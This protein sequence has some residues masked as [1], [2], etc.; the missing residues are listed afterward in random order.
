MQGPA[1]FPWFTRL[2]WATYGRREDFSDL[3]EKFA[4]QR[5][6]YSSFKWQ[7]LFVFRLAE[8]L[9]TAAQN[10][11]VQS[12]L[13][14]TYPEWRL[15][16]P[17]G[18]GTETDSRIMSSGHAISGDYF[19]Q[20]KE[21][22]VFHPSLL[23]EVARAL[24]ESPADLVYWN[25]AWTNAEFSK[26]EGLLHRKKFS[27]E[28]LE[29]FDGIGAASI[30]REGLSKTRRFIPQ[31]LEFR[32]ATEEPRFQKQAWVSKPIIGSHL[33]SV[34]LC[35][36]NRALETQS[37]IESLSRQVGKV[38]VELILVDHSSA[39][40][41]RNAVETLSKRLFSSVKIVDYAG[42][43]HFAR[44]NNLAVRSAAAGDLLFFLNN[45]V[46]IQGAN[47]LDRLAA[48]ALEETTGTVSGLLRYPEGRIQQAGLSA[49]WGGAGRL[50]RVGNGMP[51]EAIAVLD[52]EVFAN[53][54]AMA[55]VR[56]E[57]WEKVNGLDETQL[58]NGFGDADFSFKLRQA[59]YRNWCLGSIVAHHRE[60]LSRGTT[61]EYWEESELA[62]RY[63]AELAQMV[64][65]D[66]RW[67]KISA[68]ARG[69]ETARLAF[70]KLFL[71]AQ[72]LSKLLK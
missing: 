24:N 49:S 50:V 42:P 68:R 32:V 35:F 48:L 9:S 40:Q 28:E 58:Q 7:P 64:R 43:F 19:R 16:L 57:L 22:T 39:P 63:P 61:Y 15:I 38:P 41:E 27:D 14:Q 29:L 52:R 12:L 3:T 51:V 34:I 60:S 33:I 45:D 1:Y 11:I 69:R 56:R 5:A 20:V 6:S 37:A 4:L 30:R 71:K 13:A 31:F 21:E 23:Y 44:Q 18:T 47:Q 70:R 36:R 26:L 46:E 55:M 2:P 53:G 66:L 54:F 17:V 25:E 62:R 67:E 59:G 72:R 10:R 8:S 65:E